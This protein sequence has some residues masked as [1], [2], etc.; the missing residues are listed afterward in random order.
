MVMAGFAVG[1]ELPGD[2]RRIGGLVVFLFVACKTGIWRTGVIAVMAGITILCYGKM[3]A[4]QYPV[5]VVDRK[6]GRRP[7]RISGMTVFT[8]IGYTGCQV[9]GIGCLVIGCFMAAKTGG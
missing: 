8:C 5:I 2:M 6:S 1:R 7:S 4:L 3:G 9:V